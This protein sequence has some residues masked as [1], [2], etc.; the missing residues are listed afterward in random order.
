MTK[1]LTKWFGP[2]EKPVRIGVYERDYQHPTYQYWNGKYW[3][4]CAIG[5]IDAIT[6]T[7]KSDLQNISDGREIPW[8]GFTT[9][10]EAGE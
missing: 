5:P 6:N 8:R 1:K 2:D 7:Y 10:Q 3:C 4:R 9:N